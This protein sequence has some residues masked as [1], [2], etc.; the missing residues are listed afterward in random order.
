M[1]EIDAERFKARERERRQ[2]GSK[3]VGGDGS[4][5]VEKRERRSWVRAEDPPS[6]IAAAASD[7]STPVWMVA[8]V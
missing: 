3:A 2:E 1:P 6:G 4:M 5:S 8:R 7:G